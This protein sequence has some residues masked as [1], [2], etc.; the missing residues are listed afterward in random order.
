[1]FKRV[2]LRKQ[3]VVQARGL[4][5]GRSQAMMAKGTWVNQHGI[6]LAQHSNRES[7]YSCPVISTGRSERCIVSTALM[8]LQQFKEIPYQADAVVH[9]CGPWEVGGAVLEARLVQ[10][11]PPGD[12]AVHH[13]KVS[14]CPTAG[15]DSVFRVMKHGRTEDSQSASYVYH[16]QQQITN[17]NF[18]CFPCPM[19]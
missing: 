19:R 14:G 6:S 16:T 18:I 4:G 10:E 9:R 11:P 8:C 2:E 1:M 7:W 15:D 12:T 17:L 5:M 3:G 13:P